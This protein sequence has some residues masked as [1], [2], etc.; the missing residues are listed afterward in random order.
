[1]TETDRDPLPEEDV[2][3]EELLK[4]LTEAADRLTKRSEVLQALEDEWI[5]AARLV[6]VYKN[7]FF[8]S[9]RLEVLN[10]VA[11]PLLRLTQD[12]LWEYLLL[13]VARLT[14]PPAAGRKREKESLSV[15][16][17]PSLFG[18]D[19]EEDQ[20]KAGLQ[21]LVAEANEAAKFARQWRNQTVAHVD[22]ER[23]RDG[24]TH[25]LA[26]KRPPVA[27]PLE[28]ATVEK[29]DRALEAVHRALDTALKHHLGRENMGAIEPAAVTLEIGTAVADR[30]IQLVQAV[31]YIDA[32]ADPG[33]RKP[34]SGETASGFLEKLDPDFLEKVRTLGPIGPS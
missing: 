14:D 28:P 5:V 33:R 15:L 4:H 18:G 27:K 23:A 3:H 26:D 25:F 24:V 10:L 8:D 2:P 29:M 7:L 19:E 31:Q 6:S 9:E 1:M 11:G 32:L 13:R 20:Q 12:V 17:I 21:V 34:L 22:L 16:G 30:A